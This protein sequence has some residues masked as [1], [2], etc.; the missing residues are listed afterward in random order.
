VAAAL[1]EDPDHQAC[2]AWFRISQS[3]ALTTSPPSSS[4]L[5]WGRAERHR[6][7]VA[8][9]RPFQPL[10][11]ERLLGARGWSFPIRQLEFVDVVPPQTIPANVRSLLRLHLRNG[12]DEL[13]AFNGLRKAIERLKQFT[14]IRVLEAGHEP[15]ERGSYAV[16]SGIE[17][18][19][20]L[21]T[22]FVLIVTLVF[23]P[24]YW[25]GWMIVGV[26]ELL[27]GGFWRVRHR[28]QKQTGMR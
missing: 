17:K 16:R 21:I 26:G 27:S 6:A 12:P 7:P 8:Y 22:V 20:P 4:S 9:R 13:C 28:A 24:E 23:Q 10:Q 3:F 11:F 15:I 5:N 14:E 1:V 2:A 25:L 18:V 19:V